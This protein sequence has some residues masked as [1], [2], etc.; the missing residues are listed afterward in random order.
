MAMRK[1]IAL[2]FGAAGLAA[3]VIG[4]LVLYSG[5]VNIGARAPHTALTTA[6][7]HTAF[8]RSVANHASRLTAPDDLDAPGRIALGAQTYDQVCANCH[9]TPGM[10]QNP[11]ALSMRPSPQYLPAVIGQ[12][13]D[14]ELAW[15]VENG[16][17]FSAMPAWPAE[18]RT[19]ETWSMV[20]FLRQL[21]DMTAAAYQDMTQT[22]LDVAAMPLGTDF[23]TTDTDMP[24][25]SS[26]ADEYAWQVPAAGFGG[27]SHSDIPVARCATCHGSDGR[28]LVTGGEAPNLTIQSPEY[29]HASL[30]A[31]ATGQ[32]HSGFMQPQA[33]T[34]TDDQMSA[35]A[36]YF[37]QTPRAS[38]V[39]GAASDEL[40]AQGRDIALNGI[41]ERNVPACLSCHERGADN[42][43]NGLY[44]PTL[45]G[46]SETYL[47][48]QL[49]AFATGNRGETGIYN[50]MHAEA[51]GLTP[52][53]MEAVSAY[54]AAQ[55]PTTQAAVLPAAI[56]DTALTQTKALIAETCVTC[57]GANL[58]GN[59][60]GNVP[61]LTLQTAPY[62]YETLHAFR[63][64]ARH[65]EQMLQMTRRLTNEDI[66]NL[67][68]YVGS[69]QPVA[70]QQTLDAAAVARGETLAMAGDPAR[71]LPACT[72]CH[73]ANTAEKLP[74]F[75]RLNGQS[76]D[77][78]E[79]RL[80]DL[81]EANLRKEMG[82]NPMPAIAV[83]LSDAERAD[84]AAYFA[85]L[86]PLPK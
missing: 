20:A 23:A 24:R 33:A 47:K 77:Y 79:R 62:L 86:P 50:P 2:Y 43:D 21:P 49:A 32:R 58:A 42:P 17:R 54:L 30:Q 4:G 46:Q 27:I 85:S 68:S 83:K 37:T 65:A 67:A 59:T 52:Q 41:P 84:L 70:P 78:L 12:F 66:T 64:N 31:Y 8:E 69:L 6:V 55:I 63:D 15:I 60:T 44:F 1:S 81:S 28:G 73:G 7:L 35:L 9:G 29:L 26:P 3:A 14:P 80:R 18:G 5:V 25:R 56:E 39:T 75:A 74:L 34:L 82:L 11:I 13:T 16:V 61:N 76:A 10:G 71:D 72:T 36:D 48:R 38:G 19:D 40:L 57:H 45:Y 22:K 53:D 51:H